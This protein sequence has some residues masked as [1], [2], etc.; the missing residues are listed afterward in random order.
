MRER[1]R[2]AGECGSIALAASA[3]KTASE[4]KQTRR[5]GRRRGEE[6]HIRASQAWILDPSMLTAGAD[7]VGWMWDSKHL[8]FGVDLFSSIEDPQM[9]AKRKRMPMQMY[10][11]KIWKDAHPL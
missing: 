3:C 9:R 1:V 5:G 7:V 2:Q 6:R 4:S 10:R 8:R 11:G